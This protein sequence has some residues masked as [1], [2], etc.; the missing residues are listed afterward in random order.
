MVSSGADL[1]LLGCVICD[2]SGTDMSRSWGVVQPRKCPRTDDRAMQMVAIQKQSDE[3][4][5]QN[6]MDS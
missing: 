1:I 2:L 4:L 3:C 6:N 5:S